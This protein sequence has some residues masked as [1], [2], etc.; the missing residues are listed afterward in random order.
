MAL[1]NNSP[2]EVA[3]T[4]TKKFFT[5]LATSLKFSNVPV[6]VTPYLS[7]FIQL[8]VIQTQPPVHQPPVDQ[9]TQTGVSAPGQ[10]TP[11]ISAAINVES[12][13]DVRDDQGIVAPQSP[14]QV[15]EP[16]TETLPQQTSRPKLPIRRKQRSDKVGSAREPTALPP[17]KKSKP[18]EATVSPSVSSQQDMDYEMA[19]EQYLGSFSQQDDPIEIRH[20]AMALVKESHTLALLQIPHDILVE[21]VTEDTVSGMELV[22]VTV[23]TI[24]TVEE[25]SQTSEGKSDP[26]PD[27]QGSFSPLTEGT[28]L[29]PLRD[30]PLADL[31]GESG[32]Q[33]AE[34]TS[35]EY[36]TSNPNE[37]VDSVEDWE[38]RT[39]IAPPLTSLEGARVISLAGTSR[40]MELV[41]SDTIL[42]LS[43]TVAREPSETLMSDREQSAHTDTYTPNI[44]NTELLEQIK[45]LQA[46]LAQT[47]AENQIY[48][49]QVEERSSSSTSVQ[50]QLFQLKTEVENIRVSLIPRLNS[51]QETQMNQADDIASTLDSHAQLAN[52]CLQMDYLQGQIFTLQDQLAHTDADMKI[53]FHKVEGSIDHLTTGISL[54][55]SMV[56]KINNTTPAERTFFEGGSGGGGEG[57]SGSGAGSGSGDKAKGKEDPHASRAKSVEDSSTKGEKSKSQ[58]PQPQDQEESRRDKGKGKQ[59]SSYEDYY[60]Q[61]EQDDFDAFNIQ[62]EEEHE[63][64]E[65]PGVNEHEEEV[66]DEFEEEAEVPSDPAFTA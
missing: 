25:S 6:V 45:Q 24:V 49:A 10:V 29:S 58:Q 8:P 42:N 44:Q 5:R 27:L 43:E 19:N 20:R 40:Q 28:S 2:F 60:Y 46:E 32:R 3:Q 1:F 47:K 35:D 39:P 52:Y 4:T 50:N 12:Q 48:K 21:E 56:K 41:M 33:L 17:Q 18:N 53:H 23:P 61:G 7:N 59:A 22:S 14:T 54:L 64:E 37:F 65:L 30:F 51:I 38:L 55:Y 9:S 63:D 31:S 15:V 13:V 66:F 11:P 62:Q 16:N 57:G 34:F 26:M 36:Q